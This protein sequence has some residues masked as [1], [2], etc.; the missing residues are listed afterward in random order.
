MDLLA[1]TWPQ[2]IQFLDLIE[3]KLGTVPKR[4]AYY[5]GA[6]ERFVAATGQSAADNADRMLPWTMLRDQSVEHAPHLFRQES[7]VCAF[8]ETALESES[9]THFLETAVEFVNE[10]LFGTLSASVTVPNSFQNRH[11]EALNRAIG[12]LRYGSVC[13]NQW[14]GL[15]YGMMTP[16]W[17]GHPS[18][19]LANPA[20]GLGHVH[21]A[22]NIC[23]IE[24]SVVWGPLTNFP[25][26][27]W[28]PG[29]RS[30]HRVSW[31]LTRF[32]ERPSWSRLPKLLFEAMRG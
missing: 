15:A 21:N 29:H 28:L 12:D 22:F 16:A 27:A 18:S 10:Q 5:P 17:G 26:P 4:F 31:A 2:R 7:F 9:D 32:Y 14:S 19:T 25:K 11:A 24:K 30:A 13:I 23:D 20:S 8:A 3:A 1:L 6:V